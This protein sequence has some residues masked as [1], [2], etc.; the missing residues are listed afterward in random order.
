MNLQEDDGRELLEE[1]RRYL[2]AIELFRAE[3][4]EPRWRAEDRTVAMRA[5]ADLVQQALH[6]LPSSS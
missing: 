1:V 6:P 3:G 2:A 5:K 4:C